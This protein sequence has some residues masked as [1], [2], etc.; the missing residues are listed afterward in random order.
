M[1]MHIVEARVPVY[2]GDDHGPALQVGWRPMEHDDLIELVEGQGGVVIESMRLEESNDS[3][4]RVDEPGTYL[5]YLL[6]SE[7]P[8]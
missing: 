7:E 8:T 4:V 1:K 6:T 5:I 3:W 2:V